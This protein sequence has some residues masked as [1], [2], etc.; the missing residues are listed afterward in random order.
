M[1]I[2]TVRVREILIY[3]PGVRVEVDC[4]V[5][6]GP[7]AVAEHASHEALGVNGCPVLL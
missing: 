6:D 5:P 3:I 4:R 2:T 7:V 1:R